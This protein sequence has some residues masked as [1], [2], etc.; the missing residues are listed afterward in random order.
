M[1]SKL[2]AATAAFLGLFAGQAAHAD[3]S[4]SI[5]IRNIQFHVYDLDPTDGEAATVSLAPVTGELAWTYAVANSQWAYGA[6]NTLPSS[7]SQSYLG[8]NSAASL[9]GEGS[10]DSFVLHAQANSGNGTS[11]S[12]AALPLFFT[13][14]K[15]AMLVL[16][17]DAISAAATTVGTTAAGEESAF[18]KG[19]VAFYSLVDGTAI[20]PESYIW[21]LSF[22]SAAAN[23]SNSGQIQAVFRNT[24]DATFNLKGS[25]D[26]RA[27]SAI[28]LTPV[29]E[30]ATFAMLLA[31]LGVISVLRRRKS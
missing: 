23:Y 4:A 17:A 19:S 16:S 25:F 1:Q 31:G 6:M 27:S 29:P 5:T 3:A 10:L 9:L 21:S 7:V 26:L 8:A 20:A 12:L 30:P 15:N 24:S 18:G 11:T 2:V 14:S 28:P 22:G 13:L